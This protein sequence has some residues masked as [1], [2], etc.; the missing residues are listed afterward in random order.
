MSIAS[1]YQQYADTMEKAGVQ[2]LSG[3]GTSAYEKA[4]ALA[5]SDNHD[6]SPSPSRQAATQM[7]GAVGVGKYAP[8]GQ[9][10]R[11]VLDLGKVDPGLRKR[12]RMAPKTQLPG[13]LGLG[14]NLKLR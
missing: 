4:Q 8:T 11:P 13:I 6:S 9:V 2:N 7:S 12:L 1:A 14:Q 10:L 3:K 5:G